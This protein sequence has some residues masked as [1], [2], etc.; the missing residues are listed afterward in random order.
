MCPVSFCLGRWVESDIHRA[1]R[2][3]CGLASFRFPGAVCGCEI[4]ASE[5]AVIATFEG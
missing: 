5:V 1:A 4:A 2:V 3:F